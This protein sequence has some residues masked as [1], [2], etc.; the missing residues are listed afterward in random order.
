VG[1]EQLVELGVT[2]WSQQGFDWGTLG[3][4]H[5]KGCKGWGVRV[6]RCWGYSHGQ[7]FAGVSHH[8]GHARERWFIGAR[9]G[10]KGIDW[11][12]VS[13]GNNQQVVDNLLSLGLSNFVDL[14]NYFINLSHQLAELLEGVLKPVKGFDVLVGI[15]ADIIV[16]VVIIDDINNDIFVI[17]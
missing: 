16:I 2:I 15:G 1:W 12:A 10:C 6:Q 11:G 7:G 5:C 3:H 4:Q 17:I 8:R 14:V 9:V 13:R